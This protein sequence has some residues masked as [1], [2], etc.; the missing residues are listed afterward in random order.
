MR[1]FPSLGF[2]LKFYV[3]EYAKPLNALY[4]NRPS[5][6]HSDSISLEKYSIKETA[7]SRYSNATFV[8]AQES[9]HIQWL[10]SCPLCD[11]YAFSIQQNSRQL[12]VAVCTICKNKDDILTGRIV[13]LSYL[14]DDLNPWQK[15]LF[16]IEQ[17]LMRKGCLVA[18][19]LASHPTYINT[20]IDM[21][22]SQRSSYPVAAFNE[23]G[24][25]FFLRDPQNNLPD[26]S[27]ESF[28]WTFFEGD[29]A[30]R[31]F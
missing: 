2:K 20:L 5:E 26:I 15:T 31:N 16:E 18:T 25:P 12:G 22:Y 10:L 14:G 21:G 11:T 29:M 9:S 6:T 28:H 1:I 4:K 17:F 8:N 13:H 27:N 30:Y 7:Q 23:N 3:L 24:R 19:A